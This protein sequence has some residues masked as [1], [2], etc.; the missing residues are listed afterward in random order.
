MSGGVTSVEQVQCLLLLLLPLLLLSLLPLP[1]KE[2]AVA[3]VAA[4]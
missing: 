4:T 2:M 3:W 1:T